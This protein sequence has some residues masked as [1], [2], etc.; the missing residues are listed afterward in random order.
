[1]YKSDS[2]R[3][4]SEGALHHSYE[5]GNDIVEAGAAVS[6]LSPVDADSSMSRK[7]LS[8]KTMKILPFSAKEGPDE[9]LEK[10]E[11]HRS[12]K[13][14]WRVSINTFVGASILRSMTASRRSY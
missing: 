7:L 3:D 12:G 6:R 11:T 10:E 14:L 9:E 5:E 2:A 8:T 4:N 1:M 13:H